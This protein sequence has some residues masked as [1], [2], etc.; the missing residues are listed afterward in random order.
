MGDLSNS[1]NYSF[2]LKKIDEF[3]RKYYLN[4]IIRGTI[5][6]AATL[7]ASYILV[8]FAEYYGNFNPGIR[9]ALFY[10]FIGIN[11]FIVVRW[12]A[13]PASSYLKLG[14]AISYE[15][16][17]EIIGEHFTDV[18]DKLLNTLQL[19][20][21]SVE[22]TQHLALVEAS[23]NQKIDQLSP[24]P[25]TSAVKIQENR[26]Y[27]KYALAPFIV[28]LIIAFSAPA[29][30]SEST[31]RL[32]NHD[33]RFIKKAPFQFVLLNNKLSAVE[34]DD[35]TLQVKLTG[36]EIPQDIYLEDGANSFKLT[37]E[38]IVRFNYTFTNIQKSK[39]IRLTAGEYASDEYAI[40]VKRKPSLL[41]FDVYLQ[42][43][44]Y[45]G[46]QNETLNNSG[47][48]TVPAGTRVSWKFKAKNADAIEVGIGKSTLSL[49]PASPNQFSFVY[50]AMGNIQY[51][52]K[53][54]NNE[55]ISH[56][57]VVYKLDV[58]PDLS[59]SIQIEE[60]Q[61]SV[62]SKLKFFVG[63]VNDDYGFTKLNFNYRV[64]SNDK[65]QKYAVKPISFD[66]NSIQSSFFHA[67]DANDIKAEP[68]Q[69]VEYFFEVFDNDGV[70]G[71]KSS[72]SAT[73]MLKMPTQEE[74][75]NKISE[76]SASVKQKMEEAIKQAAQLES[77]AKKA[78]QNLM[79]KRELTFEEKKQIEQLLEKQKN[80]EALV[81]DIQKENKQNLFDRQDA[82]KQQSQEMLD[83]QK[84]IE[85]LFN[86]V[87]D[88]KT[89]ELLKN[90]QR[91]LEQNNKNMT[92]EELSKMQMDNKSLQK[93]LDRI[94]DLY[95]Q[96][97]FDQ[98]LTESIDKLKDMA[99]EQQKLSEETK[100][101]DAEKQDNKQ[102]AADADAL[103]QKQD[104]LSKDFKDLHKDLLDL[105][106]KNE[107]LSQKGD[108][109]NPEKEQEQ[110]EQQQQQSSKNLENKSM[111]KAAQNQEK[112]AQQMKEMSEKMEQMQQQEEQEENQVNMQNLRDI[113]D[114]LVSSSFDQEI[115]MQTLR[116]TRP[117][118]PNYVGLAQ[119]QKD[120]LDN[121]KTVQDSLYELSKK[122]PQIQ[123]VVN[124]EIQDIN[125]NINTALTYLGD[126]RTAEANRSQQYAMTAINNLALMLSEAQEQMQQAMKNAQQGKGKGKKPSLSQLSQ[127]QKQLNQNMQKAREQM[128]QQGQQQPGQ[129]QGQQPGQQGQGQGGQ[130]KGQMSEQ[131][132][133]MAREQQSIRQA[134]Q[135]INRE[136]NKDGKGGL[137]NL[138]QLSK[139]ME[140]TETDLVNKKIQQETLMRQQEILTKLLDAEKAE[141][142]REQDNKRE[143][144]QGKDMAPNYKLVLDEYKKVKQRETELLKTVPPALNSFYKLKVGDYFKF[145][146]SGK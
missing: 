133:R 134:M 100:Q 54:V 18:K 111:Q 35:Y 28:I 102:K 7:F 99:K 129:K 103:K 61:D 125:T 108:F 141:R 37:K 122:V 97:E 118:D 80:L 53:P 84:Q 63:Q 82:N 64:L 69:Q 22:S 8:T 98:K 59:P 9:T 15:Q 36:N 42:Y 123:S 43:P 116:T 30:F 135:Q 14:K 138:D 55:V 49:L 38:N 124:K 139:E 33:K 143:S 140:Q 72:R 47:D 66:R 41:N 90:I 94:L 145:L 68:G 73:R 106:Q 78:A 109:K 26:R 128:Q 91:L 51:T 29:I 117:G 83:K 132:A 65:A 17:S 32:L 50:R 146:N 126:R 5:Y 136:M 39:K 44:S 101:K 27:I 6:L 21:L 120:V 11:A 60:R 93:E 113:L 130:G 75:E 70:H 95:K 96:L 13:I 1:S 40:E 144:K 20:K 3:I 104:E 62:N 71:P 85:D 112:A 88:E 19:K 10:A 16:A 2:L 114:K 89:K 79:N 4:K 25:F 81:K 76:S 77:G 107:E 57:S 127:M 142:E 131:L 115:V 119:K 58:I 137:G 45:L 86:N 92:Q 74:M 34:G 105:E 24:V 67:W 110:I 121:M 31:E 52:L 12:I 23:I 56:D 46:K 87:L 48:L